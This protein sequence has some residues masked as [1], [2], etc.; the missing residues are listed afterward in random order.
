MKRTI[1][2]FAILIFSLNTFGS[3]MP[4]FELKDLNGKVV[5]SSEFQGKVIL[6]NF[7]ATWCPPC[8]REIPDFIE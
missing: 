8:K 3:N 6:I 7:W 1:L 5:K 2:L 4:Y